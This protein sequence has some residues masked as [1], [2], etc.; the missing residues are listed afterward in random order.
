MD[1]WSGKKSNALKRGKADKR[2]NLRYSLAQRTVTVK[3][4]A[5]Q[6]ETAKAMAGR[7]NPTVS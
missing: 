7:D 5:G 1:V 2:M 4:R 6:S 3:N